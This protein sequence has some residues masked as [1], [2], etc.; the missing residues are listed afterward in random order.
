MKSLL[1][2]E[3]LVNDVF[4][5]SEHVLSYL[6]RHK[7]ISILDR[8]AIS[9]TILD[10]LVSQNLLDPSKESLDLDNLCIV[11]NLD[12]H[13]YNPHP[14]V[15]SIPLSIKESMRKRSILISGSIPI[16]VFYARPAGQVSFCIYDMNTA[17]SIFFP[18]FSFITCSYDSPTREN[19]RAEHRPFLEAE[20]NGELYLIDALT[21]RIFKSSWFTKKYNLII[22]SIRSSD[23]FDE[24]QKK[25]YEEV[26]EEVDNYGSYLSIAMPLINMMNN[27]PKQEETIYEMEQ[28][29]K[30]FK[31]AFEDC[32]Q[33]NKAMA[34]GSTIDLIHQQSFRKLFVPKKPK[35]E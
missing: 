21:K 20:I 2:Y 5:R 12:H 15:T 25:W 19:I 33:I 31:E 16:S 1:D 4:Y 11:N 35:K 22:E 17:L 27:H 30:Y 3:L 9:N 7:N 18:S 23:T 14:N 10:A 24:E 6:E 28:S 29:R 26:T 32:E 13:V 34:D 8:E